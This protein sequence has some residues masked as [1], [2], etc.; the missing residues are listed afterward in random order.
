MT[1][2]QANN[3]V[4]S[5][6]CDS[7]FAALESMVVVSDRHT[8]ILSSSQEPAQHWDV[9]MQSDPLG[10]RQ[11]SPLAVW[12]HSIG[13]ETLEPPIWCGVN[14]DPVS[15]PSISSEEEDDDTAFPI[16]SVFDSPETFQL[17]VR[18]DANSWQQLPYLP[19][20]ESMVFAGAGAT[21]DEAP[22]S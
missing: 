5:T 10:L 11:P 4:P 14:T 7:R 1:V 2:E 17:W 15:S 3:D 18:N 12:L 6:G 8:P 13:A 21:A 9:F 22:K 16:E 19:V 20:A